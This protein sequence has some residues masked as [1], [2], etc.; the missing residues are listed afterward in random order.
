MVLQNRKILSR[1]KNSVKEEK[2]G[3]IQGVDLKL[4]SK[5]NPCLK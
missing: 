5:L 3:E 2:A 1:G 4:I